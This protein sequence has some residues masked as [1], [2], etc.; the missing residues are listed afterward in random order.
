[1][2][3][4][5][6]NP[7]VIVLLAVVVLA[8][9]FELFDESGDMDQGNDFVLALL[10]AFM[11]IGLFL[12]CRGVIDLLFRLFRLPVIGTTLQ[13]CIFFV[14]IRRIRPTASPPE[15]FLLLGSLRI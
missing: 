14:G 8:P 7:I 6:R 5:L 3:P 11:A 13:I 10:A 4:A 15:S 9:L 1:M 2:R 12:I